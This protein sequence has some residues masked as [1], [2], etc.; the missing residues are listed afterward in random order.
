MLD[1]NRLITIARSVGWA[2]G[3]LSLDL[4]GHEPVRRSN[5]VMVSLVGRERR[6]SSPPDLGS[7]MTFITGNVTQLVTPGTYVGGWMEG[8]FYHLDVSIA[9]CGPGSA[10]ALARTNSQHAVFDLWTGASI[11]ANGVTRPAGPPAYRIENREGLFERRELS[12]E[13]SPRRQFEGSGLPGLPCRGHNRERAVNRWKGLSNMPR[14]GRWDRAV[15]RP[16]R[17]D[18][19]RPWNDE[20]KHL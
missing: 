14:P 19:S 3:G 11:Y 13:G 15:Y 4:D 20:G 10:M 8:G 17:P 12:S 2:S 16:V 18:E 9:I 6:S 7:L 5:V 1:E